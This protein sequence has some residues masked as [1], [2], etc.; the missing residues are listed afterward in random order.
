[1]YD[2]AVLPDVMPQVRRKWHTSALHQ[3]GDQ[4]T[5][6]G[7]V[8]KPNTVTPRQCSF[9]ELHVLALHWWAQCAMQLLGVVGV[10]FK[11]TMQGVHA[12]CHEDELR[13]GWNV[14]VLNILICESQSSEYSTT[15]ASC[16]CAIQ[17][18]GK[19]RC[20]WVDVR[21]YDGEALG[22]VVQQGLQV[23]L[24]VL[25]VDLVVREQVKSADLVVVHMNSCA[26]LWLA[27]DGSVQACCYCC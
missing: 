3:D 14:I 4:H 26:S 25:D 2:L 10:L 6:G 7:A 1:M 8:N 24:A 22:V 15:K 9:E 21:R 11:Q 27:C 20:G 16:R 19:A 17:A 18:G 13:M 5:S 23:R 12:R